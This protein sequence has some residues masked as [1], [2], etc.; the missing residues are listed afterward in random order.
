[1]LK[2]R[3]SMTIEKAAIKWSKIIYT[4]NNNARNKFP[5]K[6]LSVAADIC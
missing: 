3:L 1:M 6:N 4:S 5:T 2:S